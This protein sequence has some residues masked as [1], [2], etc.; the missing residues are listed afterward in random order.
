MAWRWACGAGARSRAGARR[1]EK[2]GAKRAS[3]ISRLP[4]L[5]GAVRTS[6]PA[7]TS[8][9]RHPS[10]DAPCGGGRTWSRQSTDRL[11]HAGLPHGRIAVGREP[12]EEECVDR[13]DDLRQ[14]IGDVAEGEQELNASTVER[15]S[16][17]V[18]RQRRPGLHEFAGRSGQH[19]AGMRARQVV[20]LQRVLLDRDEI[21]A[22]AAPHVTAPGV[23]RGEE[24]VA[25]AEARLEDDE[26]LTPT[27]ALRQLVA[28]QEDMLGLRKSPAQGVIAVAVLRRERHPIGVE[29]ELRGDDR[30]RLHARSVG[31]TRIA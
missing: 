1:G 27:P 13:G 20:A 5:P 2:R 19:R 15:Q 9:D 7:A 22:F 24:V 28:A 16:M 17:K 25:Q 10:R 6:K 3:V 18:R 8:P 12:V 23:P 14:P 4:P 29:R 21:Q 26:A 31:S 11:E 30:I